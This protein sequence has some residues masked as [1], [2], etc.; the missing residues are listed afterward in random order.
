MTR[1]GV[2]LI[3]L[4]SA[5]ELKFEISES[6]CMFTFLL[7]L[8]PYFLFCAVCYARAEKQGAG[9]NYRHHDFRSVNCFFQFDKLK[10]QMGTE[11]TH[12]Q[13]H[14]LCALHSVPS[15]V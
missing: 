14:E 2:S 3:V 13:L 1:I 15:I 10:Q 6:G 4:A 8:I 9:A 12:F 5:Q 7:F 11:S